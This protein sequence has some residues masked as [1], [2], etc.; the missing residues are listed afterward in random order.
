[1]STVLVTATQTDDEVFQAF[2]LGDA[3]VGD[4]TRAVELSG[5]GGHVVLISHDVVIAL[6]SE[7]VVLFDARPSLAGCRC[8][9]R[10]V[11]HVGRAG[12]HAHEHFADG[13]VQYMDHGAFVELA[14]RLGAL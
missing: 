5:P 7:E 11:A 10:L 1:M 13:E 4:T 8:V 12:V 14:G 9:S 2:V 3:R 6:R